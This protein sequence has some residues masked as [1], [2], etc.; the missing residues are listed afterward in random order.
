MDRLLPKCLLEWPVSN[1][2]MTRKKKSPPSKKKRVSAHIWEPY[3]S[4]ERSTSASKQNNQEITCPWTVNSLHLLKRSAL[5]WIARALPT[6]FLFSLGLRNPEG[7]GGRVSHSV[8]T[9]S[10]IISMFRYTLGC[11]FSFPIFCP[12]FFLWLLISS[13]FYFWKKNWSSVLSSRALRKVKRLENGSRLASLFADHSE[14]LPLSHNLIL[15]LMKR[16]PHFK[17]WKLFEIAFQKW[18]N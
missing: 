18:S 8:L 15:R 6:P 2:P 16:H 4:S 12:L 9:T 3:F 13:T 5:D 1:P 7:G 11:S 14:G 10:H 17:M